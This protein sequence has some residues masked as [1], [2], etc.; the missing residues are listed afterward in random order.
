MG[1]KLVVAV[2]ALLLYSRPA[3]GHMSY[4]SFALRQVR[5]KFEKKLDTNYFLHGKAARQQPGAV[6]CSSEDGPYCSF[7]NRKAIVDPVER[8]NS[9]YLIAKEGALGE[10]LRRSGGEI[11]YHTQRQVDRGS[12]FLFFDNK[13]ELLD[14]LLY[15]QLFARTA[16]FVFTFETFERGKQEKRADKVVQYEVEGSR[17]NSYQYPFLKDDLVVHVN[18]SHIWVP[19]NS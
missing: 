17:F 1:K 12:D 3:L 8:N 4:D 2:C 18:V 9:A 15:P 6:Q 16:H 14:E 5:E 7:V 11:L 19:A 10:V 13:R